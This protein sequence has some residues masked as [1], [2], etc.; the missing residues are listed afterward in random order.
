MQEWHFFLGRWTP[1]NVQGKGGAQLGKQNAKVVNQFCQNSCLVVTAP[2]WRCVSDAFASTTT[3]ENAVKLQMEEHV[4][5]TFARK[6]C[7]A[8]H[9]ERDL[10]IPKRNDSKAASA[11]MQSWCRRKASAV[12]SCICMFFKLVGWGS[13]EAGAKAP[14]FLIYFKLWVCP[15]LD[16]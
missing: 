16:A 13:A 6:R 5:D 14:D 1:S 2:A 11:P 7:F 15:S 10:V 9:A 12:T 4:A 3:S 8:R